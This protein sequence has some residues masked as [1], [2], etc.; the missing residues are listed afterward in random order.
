M[1]CHRLGPTFAGIR[2]CLKLIFMIHYEDLQICCILC[3]RKYKLETLG[4]KFGE[5]SLM[6]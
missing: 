3:L 6:V 4:L 1:W 5:F 2:V